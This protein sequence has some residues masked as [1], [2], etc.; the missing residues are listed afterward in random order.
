MQIVKLTLVDDQYPIEG[1][2]H[3]RPISRGVVLDE[4]GNVALH[5]VYRDDAFGKQWY[6]ETPGGGIDPGETP[7]Q[8]VKR[9]CKEELG[10][11]VE[12][13]SYLGEVDDDY[14]LIHRHNQSHYYLC[15]KL[16]Q[17][18]RHFVS[19]GDLLIR[20]TLWIPIEE[21]IAKM[22]SQ[23]DWGVSVLVKRRELPVLRAAQEK[24]H[25]K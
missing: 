10:D 7:E 19:E 2:E 8:A 11:E 9:E 20:E 24:L 23:D 6:F 15:R 21:A 1:T 3:V 4:N 13:L 5:H 16:S 14:N 12:I 17:G 18:K 22:E 25:S